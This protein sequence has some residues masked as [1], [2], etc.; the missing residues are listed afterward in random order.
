MTYTFS[1]RVTLSILSESQQTGL[2]QRGQ[3]GIFSRAWLGRWRAGSQNG[4]VQCQ[5]EEVK[6]SFTLYCHGRLLMQLGSWSRLCAKRFLKRM[7]FLTRVSESS[8]V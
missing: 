7:E 8:E 5:K 1:G 6:L 2:R 3:R 4:G